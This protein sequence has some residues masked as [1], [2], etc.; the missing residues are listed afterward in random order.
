MEKFTATF[1]DISTWDKKPYSSTGGTRAKKIYLRTGDDMY[2]FFK[3]SKELEDG[4]LRYPLEYWS[5][6][7]SSK[8][9]QWLGFN[10]LDYNIGYDES[11]KQQIGCLSKTMLEDHED[12]LSE[13]IEYLRGFKPRYMPEKDKD[14]Y[15]FKFIQ[16]AL[17]KFGLESHLESF[18]EMLIF[19]ALI[20]NSDRHQENWG[21]IS[22]YSDKV[23]ELE[24]KLQEDNTFWEKL[25][26]KFSKWVVNTTK[27]I[28]KAEMSTK[29]KPSNTSL[30]SQIIFTDI[31]FSPIYDSGCC[32]GRELEDEKIDH[33]LTNYQALEKYILKGKGEVRFKIGKKPKHFELLKELNP[34]YP[35]I[36]EK[37]KKRIQENFSEEKLKQLVRNLD[38]NLPEAL[39][40]FKL[41]ENR[42]QF[43]IKSIDLRVKTFLAL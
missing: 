4:S 19:D 41:P 14:D 16:K 33:C 6:I 13:G 37:V 26:I 36:F 2:F 10:M 1:T 34:L 21:F 43:M 39:N 7:A 11:S 31:K 15:T 17:E 30:I 32:L 5:E 18:V 24:S 40:H 12:S 20:G 29:N 22:Y 27:D 42:K 8:I 35:E 3:G 23:R 9:G 38:T 25:R 28:R